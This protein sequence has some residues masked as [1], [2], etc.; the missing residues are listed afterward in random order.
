[1]QQ[2]SREQGDVNT[3]ELRAAY[4]DAL[5]AETRQWLERDAK[6]FFHQ[7]LS[8]PVMNVLARTEGA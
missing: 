3:G 2:V 5:D 8:T 6:V 7:A 1:M 4:V